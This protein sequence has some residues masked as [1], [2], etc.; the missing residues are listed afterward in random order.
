MTE[1]NIQIIYLF[2]ALIYGLAGVFLFVLSN[3]DIGLRLYGGVLFVLAALNTALSIL[4]GVETWFMANGAAFVVSVLVFIVPL[5]WLALL[6]LLRPSLLKRRE[7]VVSLLVLQAIPVAT[8]LL[9]LA[10]LTRVLPGGALFF[11]GIDPAAFNG[12]Y[13]APTSY[14]SGPLFLVFGVGSGLMM[15]AMLLFPL[16]AV[17]VSDRR[18]APRNSYL[19][20]WL[21]AT[22]LV[23]LPFMG[24]A[25]INTV[26]R[27]QEGSAQLAVLV[28]AGG[29]ALVQFALILFFRLPLAVLR[30]RLQRLPLR[31]KLVIFTLLI[32]LP[33]LVSLV[34][35]AG[36]LVNN[37]VTIQSGEALRNVADVQAVR[38]NTLLETELENLRTLA[39]NPDVQETMRADQA[40]YAAIPAQTLIQ[41]LQNDN[42]AWRQ[43]TD[44]TELVGSRLNNDAVD[45]IRTFQQLFPEHVDVLIVNAQGALVAASTRPEQFYLAQEP[46]YVAVQRNGFDGEYITPDPIRFSLGGPGEQ[47]GTYLTVSIRDETTGEQIGLLRSTIPLTVLADALR[48]DFFLSAQVANLF[49]S[50]DERFATTENI[51]VNIKFINLDFTREPNSAA[52]WA[53]ADF[54]GVLQLV[55]WRTLD[56]SRFSPIINAL[57]WRVVLTQPIATSQSTVRLLINASTIIV[58]L[59]ILVNAGLAVFLGAWVTQPVSDLRAAAEALVRGDYEKPLPVTGD[60]EVGQLTTAFGQLRQDIQRLT[61]Q[62]EGAV[63]TRTAQLAVVNEFTSTIVN[64]GITQVQLLNRA[65][66]LIQRNFR[67]Y[68]VSIFLIDEDSQMAVV[69]AS[70]GPAAETFLARRHSLPLTNNSVV[71]Y[72]AVNR[73]PRVVANVGED[74][75]HFKNPLLPDTRAEL[76]LPLALGERVLGVL[77]VQS[78]QLDA[79]DENDIRTFE[80]IANQIAITL[81]NARLFAQLQDSVTQMRSVQQQYLGRAW[82]DY[83]REH[84]DVRLRLDGTQ[85]L[86]T[87]SAEAA[88]AVGPHEMLV[89]PIQVRGFEI[90]QLRLPRPTHRDWTPEERTLALA[91]VEQA[92]LAIENARLLDEAQRLARREQAIT[93]I[94][95][96]VRQVPNVSN[97]LRTTLTELGEVLGAR[98]GLIRLDLDLG[99]GE[100]LQVENEDTPPSERP[101]IRLTRPFGDL[102]GGGETR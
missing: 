101:T 2:S 56:D 92:A 64:P 20:M 42:L 37:A 85:V 53:V 61:Q 27:P 24:L 79:F 98:A 76:G 16:G 80:T 55:A 48:S 32:G 60:D 8:A 99:N 82:R 6:G 17:A 15:V 84:G 19:A 54:D 34:V 58:P 63:E 59:T 73:R 10:G 46:W 87:S 93:E 70:A 50:S 45:A 90:G 13:F 91:V 86:T 9:D 71:G 35:V 33:V 29:L 38:V 97:I 88:L 47:L 28:V 21:L 5:V 11:S 49:T 51:G 1:T 96:R 66:E 12:Q 62:L 95:D 36:L 94:S 30:D 57:G 7:I 44:D 25:A 18:N 52:R 4:T 41:R 74:V 23:A 75:V 40:R 31:Q 81:E 72:V 67:F 78:T 3:R 65:V 83:T 89:L 69:A 68:Q 14:M 77:D 100:T 39:A 22:V 43:A 26:V 102:P